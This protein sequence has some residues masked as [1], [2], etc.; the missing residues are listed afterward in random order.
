M[1]IAVGFLEIG[2]LGNK[3]KNSLLKTIVI[4]GT[5]IF[6]M[7]I[8]G[9]NTAFA[10]TLDGIIGNPFY[11]SGFL[12]GGFSS[13]S[14]T[15]TWWSMTGK[16]F[17]TGLK[18]GTYY[19]FETA[20]AAVTLALVGVIV[21]KKMKFKAFFYIFNSLFHYNMES[22]CCMDLESNRMALQNGYE[23][24]CRWTGCPWSSSC[25]R[26]GNC[27]RNMERGA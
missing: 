6:V 7:A 21:L 22:T 8:I 12:L 2:E 17:N 5:A 11:K 16:Y 18:I 23:R 19:L 20:F 27:V 26:T 25:C 10:P 14:I 13:G 1:T 4:S 3:Y 15:S 9:F 24:F